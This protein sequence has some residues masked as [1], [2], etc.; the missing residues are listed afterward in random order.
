[1]SKLTGLSKSTVSRYMQKMR[2]EKRIFFSY[3]KK[4][5]SRAHQDMKFFYLA[6]VILRLKR[7]FKKRCYKIHGKK[8][9]NNGTLKINLLRKLYSNAEM[10]SK[11]LKKY[12]FK[13]SSSIDQPSFLIYDT[14]NNLHDFRYVDMRMKDNKTK[15]VEL[16]KISNFFKILLETI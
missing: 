8:I 1:M 13:I 14:E 3:G 12:G 2:K 5:K 7:D 9:A 10:T 11:R 4:T 16:D 15:L 6:S